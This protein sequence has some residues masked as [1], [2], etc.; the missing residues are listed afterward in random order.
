MEI[1]GNPSDFPISGLRPS[2]GVTKL[3][4]NATQY[5]RLS[6]DW[7]TKHSKVKPEFTSKWRF[8]KILDHHLAST[9]QQVAFCLSEPLV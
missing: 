4:F 7:R 8:Q 6:L 3:N 2:K 1:S 5:H 9:E